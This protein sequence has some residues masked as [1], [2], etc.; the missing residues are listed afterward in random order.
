MEF[1]AFQTNAY[2]IAASRNAP[3]IRNGAYGSHVR[4]LQGALMDL[5]FKMPRSVRSTGRPDGMFGP[6]TFR[7]VT[8]FQAKNGL[9]S[10]GV[11]GGKTL[12]KL[13]HL[14]VAKTKPSP[15]SLS[16]NM[17]PEPASPEY[18]LGGDDPP[19]RHDPGAGRWNSVP[20]SIVTS[21]QAAAVVSV[22]PAAYAVIGR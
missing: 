2:M 20:N 7:V 22:L 6:E 9:K 11:V 4:L 8:S 13:D 12:A 17:F 16:F 15:P 1:P 21:A 5:G 3:A 18:K 19:L 10:A 14:M